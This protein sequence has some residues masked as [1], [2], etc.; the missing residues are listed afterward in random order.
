MATT[1]RRLNAWPAFVLLK[2]FDVSTSINQTETE[3]LATIEGVGGKR[4]NE[5]DA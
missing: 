2:L 5:K 1:K 3:V 4:V